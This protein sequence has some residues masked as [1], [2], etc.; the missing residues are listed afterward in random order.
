MLCVFQCVLVTQRLTLNILYVASHILP[1]PF[2][3]GSWKLHK[4]V[5]IVEHLKIELKSCLDIVL[6]YV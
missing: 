3:V 5:V 1:R 4:P 2:L 6:N